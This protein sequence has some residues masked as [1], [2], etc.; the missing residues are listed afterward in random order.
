MLSI[1]SDGVDSVY[2]QLEIFGA[3]GHKEDLSKYKW[4]KR[5]TKCNK[6]IDRTTWAFLI[7]LKQNLSRRGYPASY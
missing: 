5:I 4:Y 3:L 7:T 1:W 2:T 6:D